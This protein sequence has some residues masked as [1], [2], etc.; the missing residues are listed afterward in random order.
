VIHNNDPGNASTEE[1]ID[2]GVLV[3]QQFI[4]DVIKGDKTYGDIVFHVD[5]DMVA[6]LAAQKYQKLAYLHENT[7][8]LEQ[9]LVEA[10]I[11]DVKMG[12]V[13]LNG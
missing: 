13:L 8:N 3:A 10:F 5:R 2:Y 11:N 4:L 6:M 12:K 7:D 1:P 9:F